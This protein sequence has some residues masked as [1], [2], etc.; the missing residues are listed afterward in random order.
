[1]V[2]THILLPATRLQAAAGS[3]LVGPSSLPIE[4]T[5]ACSGADALALC[6]AAIVAYPARW[7]MRGAGVA[8][9]VAL[10]LALNTIRIGTLGRA[11]TS[12]RWFDALHVYVWPTVLSLAIAGF[13][14][15]W[16]RVAD[17]PRW[18]RRAKTSAAREARSS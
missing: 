8:G 15:S 2:G 3:A 11:A 1:C 16:M 7:R 5:L 12:P 4:A 10:I 13:V 17:R 18:S 14:F 6:L 9:G